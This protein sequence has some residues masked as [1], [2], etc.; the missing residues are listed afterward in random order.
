MKP[1]LAIAHPA[2]SLLETL[3]AS[4]ASGRFG[5]GAADET[6]QRV[7]AQQID[8]LFKNVGPAVV[9]AGLANLALEAA[10]IRLHAITATT[11]ALWFA[12][13]VACMTAHLALLAL[14]RFVKYDE[15][16]WRPWAL[17]FTMIAFLEGV[18]WGWAPVYLDASGRADIQ[19][20]IACVTLIVAAAA[21][22]A[23]ASYLPA[24][25]GLFL[26]ATLPFAVAS[27]FS[28][29]DT[30]RICSYL[31]PIYLLTVG[32]IAI[33]ASL[34]F[35]EL[36]SLRLKSVELADHLRS[37]IELVEQAMIAKSNFLAAASHD[38]RQPVHAIS[39]FVGAL[40][41]MPLPE[42]GRRLTQQI[43]SSVVALDSL[44]GALL[45][46]S[47]LDAHSIEVRKSPFAIG[48]LLQRVCQDFA[49]EAAAKGVELRLVPCRARVYSDPILLE[50]VLRNLVSNAVRYT[51]RGRIVVGCRRRGAEI[52]I[53][54]CDTGLGIEPEHRE[55]IFKEYYQVHNPE[56]DRL[57][58]LGLGLAIVQRL[59][60]LLD[61]GLTLIS[62]PG[63]GSRFSVRAPLA[64][65]QEP[66][67]HP[68]ARSPA[69]ARESGLIAVVD[70]EGPILTGMSALLESWGY[71]VIAGGSSDDVMG[72]LAGCP[73]RPDLV[74]SDHWLREGETGFDVIERLRSEYN[75][76]LPALLISGDTSP[77]LRT[78]TQAAGAH[79]LHKPTPNGKLRA[80]ISSSIAASRRVA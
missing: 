19:L 71:T 39:L 18:G 13:I 26:P 47:R 68:E 46:I 53:Q 24:F 10:L 34:K 42:A 6:T 5:F 27:A 65:A 8:L 32:S 76:E 17:A 63:R 48:A 52:E 41:E 37:Q 45:D 38:L 28:D 66:V 72:K 12:Y 59:T 56:R 58:G 55:L 67:A 22:P 61:C 44:F 31:M 16:R 54:I 75:E 15:T 23:F 74:I 40:G 43:E 11:G 80:A 21:V 20:L 3:V 57:K 69:F 25:F 79:L 30:L 50:R 49:A 4:R 64:T 35:K 14:Y 33:Q 2:S 36:V 7:R 62:Q 77:E 29:V 70:D 51:D 73:L 1:T 78:E 60:K 9:G